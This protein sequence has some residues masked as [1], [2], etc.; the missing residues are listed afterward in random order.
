MSAYLQEMCCH[1]G[2]AMVYAEASDFMERYL[3]QQVSG[4]QI[5]R[6]C[7]YYGE[8]IEMRLTQEGKEDKSVSA[9]DKE[10]LYYVMVDGS[11]LLTREE[12]WK[13]MKAGRIFRA[14]D[15]MKLSP[16]RGWIKHSQYVAHLGAHQPFEAKM[17]QLIDNLPKK[18]FVADGAPWIWDWVESAYPKSLQILDYYHTKQHLCDFAQ[19]YFKTS[20]EQNQWIDQQETLLMNDDVEKVIDNI[21]S[22]PKTGKRLITAKQK[23]LI[24]YYKQNQKRMRY[25]TY[26][27]MGLMIGSG[28]IEATHRHLIQSRMKRSG[29]RWTKKGLQQLAN[30][31]VAHK[32][33]EWNTVIDMISLA[34]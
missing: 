8:K 27:T 1:S 28:P 30:L 9:E 2:Q 4:K 32:S 19:L 13:E 34:A 20:D 15:R 29:Q 7:H 33:N 26:K 22:L 24:N 14:E 17:E 11:M 6:I 25:K 5:E 10:E 21:R 16:K 31:R 18:V 23:T 12:S 3:I